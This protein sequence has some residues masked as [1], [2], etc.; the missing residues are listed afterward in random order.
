MTNIH[1][2]TRVLSLTS[3]QGLSNSLDTLVDQLNRCQKALNEFLEVS[4]LSV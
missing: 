4:T 1:G 2:D 3:R